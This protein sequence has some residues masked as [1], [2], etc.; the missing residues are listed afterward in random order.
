MTTGKIICYASIPAIILAIVVLSIILTSRQDTNN[1]VRIAYIASSSCLPIFV[2]DH[3][4]YLQQNGTEV[5]LIRAESSAEAIN[6]V[7]AQR[8]DIVIQMNMSGVFG[9]WGASPEKFKCFMPAIETDSDNFDYILVHADSKIKKAEDL[10]GKTVGLRQGPS[11]L[12]LGELYFRKHG[13]DPKK[14][15]IL[16]QMQQKQLLDA[17]HAKNIEAVITVD[18]DA[19]IALSKLNVAILKRFYRGEL[20][21]PFPAT[22]NLVGTRFL[23]EHSQLFAQVVKGLKRAVDDIR[24]DR[25]K[26][27]AI[28]PHYIPIDANLVLDVGIPQFTTDYAAHMDLLQSVANLYADGKVIPRAPPIADLFISTAD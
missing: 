20:L 5:I 24:T 16:L 1:T 14:D 28:L 17:L 13:V 3:H 2:A 22:C 8:A 25:S 18:P 11:D 9:A 15:L 27:L 23:Q 10:R 7:L 4:G 6:L 19:T 12:L 21:N 26:S